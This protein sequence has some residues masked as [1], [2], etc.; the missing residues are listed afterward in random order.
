MKGGYATE[1]LHVYMIGL[2]CTT[3]RNTQPR[4]GLANTMFLVLFVL[5]V[6]AFSR[7]AYLPRTLKLVSNNASVLPIVLGTLVLGERAGSLA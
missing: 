7:E 3:E 5:L 1:N 4:S 2:A 6:L